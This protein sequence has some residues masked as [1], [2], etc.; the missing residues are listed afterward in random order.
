M[1]VAVAV[2]AT[3]PWE[4]VLRDGSI[5]RDRPVDQGQK[6]V[7]ATVGSGR[8]STRVLVH[9]LTADRAPECE[10]NS[11]VRNCRRTSHYALE[12]SA[13][14]GLDCLGGEVV[15]LGWFQHDVG[16][17]GVVG[18]FV[19]GFGADDDGGDSWT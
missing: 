17:G 9:G 14:R 10:R 11:R 18:E 3:L 6:W 15:E 2:D 13:A 12:P 7:T 5:E 16:C 8:S 4:P 1:V 19:D